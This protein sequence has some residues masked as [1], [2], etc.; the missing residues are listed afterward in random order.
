MIGSLKGLATTLKT[1]FRHPVTVQYPDEH[2][3][4]APR[5]RGFSG[6][7]YDVEADEFKCTGCGVCARDCPTSCITVSSR[8]ND[9]FAQGKSKR[10]RLVKEMHIDLGR[11]LVC[12]ICAEVCPFDAMEMSHKHEVSS[13]QPKDLIVDQTVLLRWYREKVGK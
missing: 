1:F 3:P 8:E 9:K 12:G 2:L 4:L 11:C 6:L 7:I 13:Y 5:F 10:R